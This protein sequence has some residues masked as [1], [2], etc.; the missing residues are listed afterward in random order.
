M[1]RRFAGGLRRLDCKPFLFIALFFAAFFAPILFTGRYLVGGDSLIYSY[2]LRTVAWD[3]IR[4]GQLPLWTPLIL[5]GYPLL[6]MAQLGLGYPGTWSYLFLPGYLAEEIYVLLP[7]LFSPLFAYAYL[8]AV[9]CSRMAGLLGGLSFGYGGMMA[10][11]LSHNGMFT[12]AVMWLP[13]FLLAIERSR[14]WQFAHALALAALVY[15]LAIL[16]GLG[17]GFLYS[18]IIAGA[19][20]FCL[21]LTKERTAA[22]FFSLE[23]WRPLFVAGFGILFAAG[24]AAFQIL[25]TMRA[26]R[27]SI[28]SALNY[29]T[30]STGSFTASS[31]WHSFLTPLYY[32]NF[33]TTAYV[34]GLAGVCIVAALFAGLRVLPQRWRLPWP[35]WF[36]LGLSV[37]GFLLMQGDGTPVYRWIY[38]LPLVN[39][40]R[41]PWRHA[42]EFTLGLSMLAAF[43]WDAVRSWYSTARVSKRH[44]AG[45]SKG[46][47][48]GQPLADARGSV[49]ADWLGY[50]ALAAVT[51]FALW[52]MRQAVPVMTPGNHPFYFREQTWLAFK[53]SLLAGWCAL[54][55]WAWT[56]MRWRHARVVLLTVI[57]SA[58]FWE[59]QVL[60]A[61]WCFPFLPDA[62]YFATPAPSTKFMQQYEPTQNRVFTSTSTY[63]NLKLPVAEPHNISMVRGLH[64]AAGY[65]PLLPK[66]YADAFGSGML[67]NTP[68]INAPLDPQILQPAWQVL[69][70]LNVRLVADFSSFNTEFFE[71]E[72]VLFPV[73]DSQI[74]LQPGRALTLSGSDF[75]AEGVSI[76][77]TL[78]DAG[79]IPQGEPVAQL[80]VHTT[81][82]RQF[83][84]EL[85]AGVDTAEWAHER[86]DVKAHIRHNLPK[87]FD[88]SVGDAAS[89][90][91][92]YHYWT[93]FRLAQPG[94]I[95]RMVLQSKTQRAPLIVW[96]TGLYSTQP[97]QLVSVFARLPGHW[98]KVYDQDQ[99]QIYE[100]SRALPRLWLTPQAAAVSAEEALKRIRGE[101]AQ[102]FNPR[103]TALIETAA[104]GLP[105]ELLPAA[106]N[107]LADTASARYVSYQPNHVVIETNADRPAVLVVSEAHYPG[108]T[109]RL[110]GQPTAIYATDYLLR[111][112]VLPAGQHRVEMRYTAPAALSGLG[113]SVLTL[114]LL[115]GLVWRARRKT[116]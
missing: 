18:G 37:A 64:N 114:G 99:T 113:I 12:N 34:P 5:S 57:F 91:L 51:A 77:T 49:S 4:H 3:M 100:N 89:S 47:A 68:T 105:K 7:F 84:Y 2:P 21:S 29:E 72:G 17:Q 25:E 23:R 75:A 95:E 54:V 28:R 63:F 62:A 116:N 96:R 43:G 6:S 30:F 45:I 110:D 80:T 97:R 42:F 58:C 90:F 15:A 88:Q 40:F 16:T 33:E 8:R 104:A 56:K 83:D 70:L 46:A 79:D 26:Q 112:I 22:R 107:Q 27:R 82:G 32:F 86:P 85:K 108:W 65:E 53:L 76:V 59:Q 101:S 102:P 20:G 24:L 39:L 38:R 115:L 14:V 71:K 66:R 31:I 74:Q 36:W 44:L 60:V 98:R 48:S 87:V 11:G 103:Q 35:G 93:N 50:L 73:N 52:S 111:G 41:I 13:L 1:L 10:G 9:G 19:Y 92:A 106:N 81:D 94:V 69:D 55:W 78:A 61:H 67:F 109:A